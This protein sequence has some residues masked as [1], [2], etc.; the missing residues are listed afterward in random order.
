MSK[1][2]FLTLRSKSLQRCK[3]YIKIVYFGTEKWNSQVYLYIHGINHPYIQWLIHLKIIMTSLMAKKKNVDLWHEAI[4]IDIETDFKIFCFQNSFHPWKHQCMGYI[5]S[6]SSVKALVGFKNIN[7]PA[8][9][10]LRNKLFQ[11]MS[12]LYTCVSF[13]KSVNLQSIIRSR[14]V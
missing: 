9:I 11:K 6:I 12:F 10:Y 1:Q 8:C 2:V 4:L 7:L 14:G 5:V 3:K 13:F